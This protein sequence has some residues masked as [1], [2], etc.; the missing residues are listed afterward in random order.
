[1]CMAL[2][3]IRSATLRY[4]SADGGEFLSYFREKKTFL[5]DYYWEKTGKTV[6]RCHSGIDEAATR[7]AKTLNVNFK[8]KKGKI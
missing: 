1:M 2:L 8:K 6:L 7:V 4:G 3:P 5:I